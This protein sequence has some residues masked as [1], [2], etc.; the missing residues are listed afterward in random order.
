MSNGARHAVGALIG[1]LAMPLIAAGLLYGVFKMHES[2]RRVVA[3]FGG[4]AGVDGWIGAGVLV[5]TAVIVALVAA[6]RVSPIASLLPGVLFTG[7]GAMWLID[8]GWM[9][10]ESVTRDLLPAELDLAFTI[11]GPYGFFLLLGALLLAASAMPSRWAGR[12]AAGARHAAVPPAMPAGPG[13]PSGPPPVP[14]A[15]RPGAG[16]PPQPPHGR[17]EPF[18]PSFGQPPAPHGAPHGAP[19]GPPHGGPEAPQSPPQ[20][21]VPFGAEQERE[22]ERPGQ[23]GAPGEGE[24]GE[25]TRMYGGDDLRRDGR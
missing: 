4:D 20:G 5:C 25:W 7:I 22:R 17:P 14:G 2:V 6:P 8:P 16:V 10:R 23:F 19:Q 24:G 3:A 13:A 11:V 9:M 12:P 21:A 15:P 1:V 18:A